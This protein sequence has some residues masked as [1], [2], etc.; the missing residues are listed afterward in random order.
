MIEAATSLDYKP[1]QSARSLITKQ[2]KVIG[3]VKATDVIHEKAHSFDGVVDTYISEMLRSIGREIE[4]IGYS[5][6]IDWCF[7][8]GSSSELPPMVDENKVDGVLFVGGFV[9]EELVQKIKKKGVPAV[10]VGTRSDE[11]DYVDTD[12]EYGIELAVNYLA[13]HG[14][15][16]I[17]F[18]NGSTKVQSSA[19]KLKG[20]KNAIASNGLIFNEDLV[21]NSDFTGKGGYEGIQKILL[22]GYR[23]TAVIGGTDCIA[24]GVIR[25]LHEKGIYCP[26]KISVMGFE[27]SMLAEYA[28]P[29][30]SSVSVDKDRLGMEATRA[31]LNR[32][33]NPKA[34][35]VKLMI[36]PRLIE[37][38]SVT[39]L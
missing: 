2:N 15:K 29:A 25:C 33:Q 35:K 20:F 5:M 6:L 16:E 1:N 4:K 26:E 39:K 9:S 23:P 17:A 14:H 8:Y 37:R 7:G 22:K 21:E 18:I 13:E 24:I 38:N 10:L 3:V 28:V 11:L 32:I 34:K 30:L 36:E 19:R 27:D 12:P 31:L